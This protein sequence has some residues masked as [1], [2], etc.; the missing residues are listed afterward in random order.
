M[1]EACAMNHVGGGGVLAVPGYICLN[2]AHNIS[3][4]R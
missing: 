1:L 3:Y 4:A 2:R